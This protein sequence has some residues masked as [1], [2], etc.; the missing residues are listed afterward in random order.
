[1]LITYSKKEDSEHLKIKLID[2]RKEGRILIKNVSLNYSKKMSV[3]THQYFN[4]AYME[5]TFH[6]PTTKPDKETNL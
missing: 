2:S 1:M 5:E 3:P 6:D 4:G